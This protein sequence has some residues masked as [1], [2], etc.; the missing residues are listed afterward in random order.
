[1]AEDKQNGF[2]RADDVR[3]MG[4]VYASPKMMSAGPTPVSES[5]TYPYIYAVRDDCK[6]DSTMR[7][8]Y[9]SPQM[10]LEKRNLHKNAELQMKSDKAVFCGCCGKQVDGSYGICGLCGAEIRFPEP[11]TT[12]QLCRKCGR[13]NLLSNRYC[14]FCG[15]DMRM[16]PSSEKRDTPIACV[17]ASPERNFLTQKEKTGFFK[18]LFRRKNK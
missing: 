2:E 3:P 5:Q 6:D 4:C 17:Y 11:G 10:M 8:V 1:M 12:I 7:A 16:I 18:R 15:N 9:G 14:V 13:D